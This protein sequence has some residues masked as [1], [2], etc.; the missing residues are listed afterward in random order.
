MVL[1]KKI[2]DMLYYYRGKLDCNNLNTRKHLNKVNIIK[3]I[4]SGVVD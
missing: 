1:A 4:W 2:R 3:V